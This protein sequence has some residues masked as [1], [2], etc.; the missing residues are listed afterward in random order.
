[1]HTMK[2]SQQLLFFSF[3]FSYLINQCPNGLPAESVCNFSNVVCTN[4]SLK[5]K[6]KISTKNNM[7]WEEV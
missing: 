2:W 5:K 7:K 4:T 3:F 6:K 1:M